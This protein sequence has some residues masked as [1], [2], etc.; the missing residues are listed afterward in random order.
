[1]LTEGELWARGELQALLDRRFTPRAVAGF[2]AASKRRA[3]EVRRKRPEL[4]RQ[5]LAWSAAGGAA[6]AGLAVTGIEPYRSHARAGLCWW[7]LSAV[8]LDWHLGM[9]ETPDG[10]PRPLGVADA[11][12]LARV[13]L[14]PAVL[15]DPSPSKCAAGFATDVLDG[16]AARGLGEPTRAGRDL[17]GLADVCFAGALLMGLRRREALGRT[18]SGAELARL[19]VGFAYAL[20]VYFGRAEAP[21]PALTRAAR[22]TT[23]VRA[24]GLAAAATGRRRSGT[25]LVLGGCLWSLALDAKAATRRA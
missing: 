14:A 12:T 25:L 3:A 11:L 15:H 1:V 6:W 24:T 9:L 13:W 7:G 18:A 19:A 22:L 21:D 2:L 8:M 5:S 16:I 4:G 23:P 17:E 20:A 10:R